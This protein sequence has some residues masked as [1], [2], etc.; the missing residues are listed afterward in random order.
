MKSSTSGTNSP[1]LFEIHVH[2]CQ[3]ICEHRQLRRACA[4][5]ASPGHALL[6]HT[7]GPFSQYI[8]WYPAKICAQLLMLIWNALLQARIHRNYLKCMHVNLYV[9]IDNSDEHVQ[10]HSITRAFAARTHFGPI[11]VSERTQW[12]AVDGSSDKLNWS[13]ASSPTR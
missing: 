1:K 8:L 4:N 3:L 5:I 7:S 12:K 6:A 9:N 13:K 11:V 2:A 10:T